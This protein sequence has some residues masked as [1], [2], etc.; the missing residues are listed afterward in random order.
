MGYVAGRPPYT[1][2]LGSLISR[3]TA[4]VMC[5]RRC[6]LCNAII[7]HGLR[8]GVLLMMAFVWSGSSCVCLSTYRM[9]YTSASLCLPAPCASNALWFH[10]NLVI[11]TTSLTVVR[12]YTDM[13][14]AR[15][16]EPHCIRPKTMKIS[17]HWLPHVKE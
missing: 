16:T 9:Q 2:G 17:T 14:Q 15:T 7:E 12:A 5:L 13:K 6:L 3:T 10:G 8:L 11:W 4:R 1:I